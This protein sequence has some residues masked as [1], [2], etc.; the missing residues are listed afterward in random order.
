MAQ[1]EVSTS[2]DYL[3]KDG[4]PFFYLADT[5]WMAFANLP[6]EEWGHYL[7]H[8]KTQ[9]FNALQISIL[10][11][12]HDT[13]MAAEN[14]DPFLKDANGD[15]DFTAYNEAYFQKAET[16]VDMA[17]KDGFVPVLGVLWCSYVPGTRCSQGSP[18]ASAMPH[19]AVEGYAAYVAER[20]KKYD[21]VFFISGDT[22]FESQDEEPYYMTALQT[23][24]DI[25]PEALITMHLHPQGDLPRSFVDVVDFYMYQSGHSATKQDAPYL[26]A[27]RFSSYPVKRPVVNSEPPYEGHGRVGERTRFDAFDIRR[28]SWQSLLS[29]AKMGVAY[30]AHGVWSFHR[31]GMNFLNA[32]RS[33]EPYDWNVALELEGAWD[34]SFA[35][36]MFETYNLFELESADIVL[37]EDKAIRAAIN[38]AR[39]KVAVYYPYSFDI[40]FDLD[41]TGFHFVLIDL[42]SRRFAVPVVETGQVSRIRMHGFSSDVLILGIKGAGPKI[43]SSRPSSV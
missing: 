20:F 19:D 10:P 43:S 8:R 27:E 13:S 16:M 4:A 36:W 12:T 26:L 23:V 25:C 22:Q 2:K 21:P 37:N 3:V 33:F 1:L 5:A 34:V 11:V 35:K 31:C 38:E 42:T 39:T 9:G 30:G 15:W 41:L 28:A 6:L 18:V 29:G 32:H 24:K 40:E 7:S 17:V 14:L